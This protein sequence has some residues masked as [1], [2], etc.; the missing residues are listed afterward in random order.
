MRFHLGGRAEAAGHRLLVLAEAGSTN[1]EAAALARAG[2]CGPLWLVTDHQRAGRGRRN[3]GWVSPR[4]N[5]AVSF[6]QV[7]QGEAGACATLG[8]AAGLALVR[9]F[10]RIARAA[11][12]PT[13]DRAAPP[14]AFR[15]KWPN[16]VLA[17]DAKV[18]GI[19]VEADRAPGGGTACVI[20]MGI[21]VVC[22][23]ADVPFPATSLTACGL[24]T[25][26]TDVFETLSD[27]F[28][29]TLEVWKSGGMAALRDEWLSVAAG[30]GGPVSIDHEGRRLSGRFQTIDEGGRLVL[31]EAGGT[32][33]TIAAGDVF[34]GRTASAR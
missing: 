21:N 23:P 17:S 18:A 12:P 20:G 1:S 34:F 10:E 6:L 29:A 15:L 14:M 28:A 25:D 16:D 30:L 4:G 9:T 8:F 22:A 27:A 7:M 13:N 33:R 3:R 11:N 5:L 2:E 31:Q 32:Q 24:A 19:L 26:A